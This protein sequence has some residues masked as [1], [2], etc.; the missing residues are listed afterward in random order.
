M[1]HGEEGWAQG[2]K[3][4]HASRIEKRRPN[5]QKKKDRNKWLVCVCV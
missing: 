2:E 1:G 5:E 4:R 3:S